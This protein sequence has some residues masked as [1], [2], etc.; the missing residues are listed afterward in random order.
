MINGFILVSL[1]CLKNVSQNTKIAG[2]NPEKVLCQSGIQNVYKTREACEEEN[3]KRTETL[4][5]DR[6]SS[7]KKLVIMPGSACVE[8]N[9]IVS[10][11]VEWKIPRGGE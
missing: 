8:V 9:K 5:I 6:G 2:M 1:L 4:E 3:K 10:E 7:V 11:E